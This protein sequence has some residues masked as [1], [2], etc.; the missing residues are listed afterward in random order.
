MKSKDLNEEDLDDDSKA[1]EDAKQLHI[2]S[3]SVLFSP[4]KCCGLRLTFCLPFRICKRRV[5]L[6]DVILTSL[7]N[8]TTFTFENYL[9]YSF[10]KKGIFFARPF[11]EK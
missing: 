1:A 4:T 11:D 8:R 6:L 3:V 7:L 10:K 2:R 5:L 9:L